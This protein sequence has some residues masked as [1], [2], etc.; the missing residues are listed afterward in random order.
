MYG[1]NFLRR[2][3]VNTLLLP[4]LL[5]ATNACSGP[6][7][8][9]DSDANKNG[10]RDAPGTT[11]GG[12]RDAASTDAA[13]PNAL[14]VKH[15]NTGIQGLILGGI[16][17]ISGTGAY[18]V[19][20]SCSGADDPS[21][22]V[23]SI[24]SNGSTL[25]APGQCPGAPFTLTTTVTGPMT[26]HVSIT[27]GPLPVAYRSL[28]VPLD[29]RKS[30]FTELRTSA[31]GYEVGCGLSWQGRAGGGSAFSAVPTPCFIPV[32]GPVGAARFVPVPTWG[33]I[34]GRF[35]TIRRTMVSGDGRELFFYNHPNT[36]N[37]EISFSNDISFQ[38]DAGT[39]VHLEEDLLVTPPAGGYL[40]RAQVLLPLVYRAMLNR[41]PD[42][43]G[44]ASNGPRI[45]AQ[46]AVGMQAV[47]TGIAGSQEFIALRGSLSSAQLVD[48]FYR[49]ILGRAADPAGLTSFTPLIDMGK[50]TDVIG[51]LIQSGEF[52]TTFPLAFAP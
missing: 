49:G 38:L 25:F 20:G 32:A 30:F 39:V 35:G 8:N 22:S 40:T 34:S 50:Y 7:T 16:N 14:I 29:P 45:D 6:A 51:L 4:T 42:A 26:A 1:M 27:I 9:A 12:N 41:E 10:G 28:S 21:Q 5:A 11:D 23:V 47:A 37:I 3:R 31:T 17:L 19:I 24:G 48:Q 2:F 52:R 13:T 18:Y 44:I 36:N 33:E 46:G 43:S 15:N